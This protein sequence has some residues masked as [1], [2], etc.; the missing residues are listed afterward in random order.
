MF[1]QNKNKNPNPSTLIPIPKI[2]EGVD[3]GQSPKFSIE[4]PNPNCSLDRKGTWDSNPLKLLKYNLRPRSKGTL[5]FPRNVARGLVL[6]EEKNTQT[7]SKGNEIFHVYGTKTS[8]LG[9]Q[10]RETIILNCDSY[11]KYPF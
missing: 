7:K 2:V 3:F 5:D 1:F 6:F 10:V 11:R 4:N 9:S 8:F